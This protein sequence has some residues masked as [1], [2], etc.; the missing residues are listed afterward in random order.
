MRHRLIRGLSACFLILAAGAS[1]ASADTRLTY[2]VTEGS[3]ETMQSVLIGQ[4]KLRTDTTAMTSVIID[5]ATSAMI[6]LDHG[7]K[8]FM[9][10][11][12]AEIDQ[13]AA[14]MK[15][16]EQAMANMPPEMREKM[17]SMMGGGGALIT[18]VNT[19]RKDTVGGRP[20]TVSETKMQGQTVGETCDAPF[21]ALRLPEADLAVVVKA[22]QMFKALTDQLTASPVIGRMV[23]QVGIRA[24]VFPLRTTTVQGTQRTTSELASVDNAALPADLFVAPAGYKEQKM[25]LPKIGKL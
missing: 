11:G 13:L 10:M 16:L 20:C 5:P 19:G 12:R 14:M 1:A 23:S 25:D 4:G 24:D 22:S 21:S 7:K 17:K 9:R 15:Q 6:I 8:T 3:G 18:V 2:K